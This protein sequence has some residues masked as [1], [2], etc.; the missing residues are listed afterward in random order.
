MIKADAQRCSGYFSVST[1]PELDGGNKIYAKYPFLKKPFEKLRQLPPSPR[2]LDIGCGRGQ[3][4]RR[5]KM[6]RSDAELVGVDIR[7]DLYFIKDPECSFLTVN[8]EEG[9]IPLPDNSFD[10][11]TCE[12]VVEHLFN[13]NGVFLEVYRLLRPGGVAYIE[14]PDMRTTWLPQAPFAK[15]GGMNFY[16]DPTHI[17]P[18]T[19]GTFRMLAARSGFKEVHTFQVRNWAWFLAGPYLLWRYIQ[20]R[21]AA[22]LHCFVNPFLGSYVGCYLMKT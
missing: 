19:Q 14:A 18:F 6:I 12:H 7:N 5:C 4:L 22:H 9:H 10:L 11:I 21:D 3:N 17:R 8:L 1:L 20:T 13:F 2:I 16:D 15:C